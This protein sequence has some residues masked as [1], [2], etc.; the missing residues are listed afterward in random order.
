MTRAVPR[1]KGQTEGPFCTAGPYV[2]CQR[3]ASGQKVSEALQAQCADTP[4]LDVNDQ[5]CI[6]EATK[7]VATKPQPVEKLH[8]RNEGEAWKLSIDWMCVDDIFFHMPSD[9]CDVPRV[10]RWHGRV[11]EKAKRFRGVV[12]F[13]KNQSM[14]GLASV[15]PAYVKLQ[16]ATR[17]YK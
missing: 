2:R 14:V 10:A 8:L 6:V 1:E 15:V 12:V 17:L 3:H 7:V 5:L 11:S 16:Q 9:S 4:L 13:C